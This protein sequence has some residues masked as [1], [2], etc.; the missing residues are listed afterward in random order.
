MFLLFVV[1]F[2]QIFFQ[3]LLNQQDHSRAMKALQQQFESLERKVSV[4]FVFVC[5]H[6]PLFVNTLI[7]LTYPQPLKTYFRTLFSFYMLN[8][9]SMMT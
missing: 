8:S 4:C 3:D 6:Y 7:P 5:F 9:P 1:D 2:I